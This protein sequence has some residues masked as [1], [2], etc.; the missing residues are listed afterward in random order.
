MKLSERKDL[1]KLECGC[2]GRTHVCPEVMNKKFEY[3]LYR[4]KWVWYIHKTKG[5]LVREM[6]S[7]LK[8][9]V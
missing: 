3:P 7:N 4:L 2:K 6:I 5:Y 1:K 8:G 9:N